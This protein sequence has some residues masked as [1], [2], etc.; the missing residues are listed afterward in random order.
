MKNSVS[1]V[2]FVDISNCLPDD[3]SPAWLEKYSY[4]GVRDMNDTPSSVVLFPLYFRQG[5]VFEAA[6]TI[7]SSSDADAAKYW[8]SLI[9]SLT[10]P[11]LAAGV[12]HEVVKAEAKNFSDTVQ[13]EIWQIG[14]VGGEG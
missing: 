5:V 4:Q 6:N 3:F 13:Q 7:I 10:D 1:D 11:L 12:P 14:Q 8:R 2:S 9:R